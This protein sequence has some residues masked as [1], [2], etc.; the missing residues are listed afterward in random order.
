MST[1]LLTAS[2]K[3]KMGRPKI[4]I[5][6]AKGVIVA[7]RFTPIEARQINEAIRRSGESKP[8]WIRKVLLSA[9]TPPGHQ[10]SKAHGQA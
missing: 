7:A 2:V 10:R 1:F 6:N 4:G 9:A 3:K 5:N 8:G